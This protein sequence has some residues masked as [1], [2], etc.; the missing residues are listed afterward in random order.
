MF[1]LWQTSTGLKKTRS[2]HFLITLPV[3]YCIWVT[4]CIMNKMLSQMNIFSRIVWFLFDCVRC[5]Q[6]DPTW[7]YKACVVKCQLIPLLLK[8]SSHQSILTR[9]PRIKPHSLTFHHCLLVK[10]VD[11]LELVLGFICARVNPG[12]RLQVHHRATYVIKQAL[13]CYHG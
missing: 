5:N 4:F 12:H 1:I 10:T 11:M 13:T 9:A 3:A 8:L 2:Y 6:N 7:G